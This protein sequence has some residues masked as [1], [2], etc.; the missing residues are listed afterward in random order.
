[1]HRLNC[2]Y[3][4]CTLSCT[5]RVSGMG[6]PGDAE[7]ATA[8]QDAALMLPTVTQPMSDGMHAKEKRLGGHGSVWRDGAMAAVFRGSKE[9]I[10]LRRSE[11]CR[12]LEEEGLQG[13]KPWGV[14]CGYEMSSPG[15]MSD[16]DG[17]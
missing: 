9:K 13:Q 11:P 2:I 8:H 16:G 15:V 10:L 4:I 5:Y 6:C 17:G 7:L 3:A 14:G 12:H 1:M